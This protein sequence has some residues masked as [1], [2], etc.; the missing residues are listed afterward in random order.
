MREEKKN[1]IEDT[2][3]GYALTLI[4]GNFR[5]PIFYTLMEKKVMRFNEMRRYIA[6][7][8]AR[9]LTQTLKEMEEEGLVIRNEVSIHPLNV[10]YSLTDYAKTLY[11]I[12]D[13]IAEWGDRNRIEETEE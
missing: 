4:G 10:E 3:F 5:L 9:T 11:P 6:N 1:T 8:S 7:I 2:G 13:M 12:L